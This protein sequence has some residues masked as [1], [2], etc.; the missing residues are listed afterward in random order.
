MTEKRGRLRKYHTREERLLAQREYN[1]R[2]YEKN[3]YFCGA[4]K[5]EYNT[6]FIMAAI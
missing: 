3:K 2:S 4:C 1:A 6:T 5:G